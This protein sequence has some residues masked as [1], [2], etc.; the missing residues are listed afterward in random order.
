MRCFVTGAS[1]FIGSATASQL[2]A[3]GHEVVGLTSSSARAE[4]LRIA[5]I[6][7]IVGDLRRP[8]AWV[9]AVREAAAVIHLATL[10]V[11]ARPGGRYVR[12]LTHAH[13]TA[14]SHMLEAL[15]SACQAFVYTSGA[16]VYGIGSETKTE[17]APLKPYRIAEP[18]AAGERLVLAAVRDVGV[19]GMVL[20]PGG[21]YGLG[22][23]FARFWAGPM[24]AGRRAAIPGTG[25]QRF[26]FVHIDDCVQAYVRCVENPMPGEIFNVTDD[27][28]VPLGTMIRALAEELGAP[29]PCRIPSSLFRLVAGPLIAELLLNDKAMSNRKMVERL[30]VAL[31]FPTYRQGIP[32][33][34]RS[35]YRGGR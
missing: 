34:A 1:G 23:V 5:G 9:A 22:G 24:V 32:A 27:E 3:R 21:V 31:R 17:A 7:P 35:A 15:S 10:P 20:R 13:E 14:V 28:P 6:Q 8:E 30:G 26:S 29:R 33:L 25:A 19:P 2:V 16:S 12:D 11:P 18:Y 4:V